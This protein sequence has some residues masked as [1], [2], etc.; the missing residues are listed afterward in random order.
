MGTNNAYTSLASS[1]YGVLDHGDKYL[2]DCLDIAKAFDQV[3]HDILFM[4]YMILYFS[5][6]SNVNHI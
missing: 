5:N 2:T 3:S 6:T 1:I 4:I